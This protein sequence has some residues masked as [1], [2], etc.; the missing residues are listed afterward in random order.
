MKKI[1]KIFQK[2]SNEA[3]S[4]FPIGADAINIDMSN[5]NN[6]EEEI[7]NLWSS[8]ETKTGNSPIYTGRELSEYTWAQLEA[9]CTNNDFKDLRI[10][11][12]KTILLTDGEKV[13]MQIAGIDTYYKATDV[14]IPHHI[15]WI[16]ANCL[17]G[18]VVWN[19]T[20]NNNGDSTNN[21]PYMV[22]NVRKYLIETIYPKLPVDVKA[23]IKNK[24]N[25][26]ESRYSNYD[27]AKDSIGWTWEDMGP[28][29]LPSECEVFGTVIWGTK[30]Y[31]QC[32]AVQYPLFANSCML[33]VKNQREMDEN[34]IIRGNWWLSTVESGNSTHC[35]CVASNG[36]PISQAADQPAIG[37]P[38]CFRISA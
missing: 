1:K 13:R 8:Y 38:L 26:L 33:R 5:G 25:L 16:S 6:L 28:I 36:I 19:T 2:L 32:Q 29:W 12:Y 20:R 21:S 30:G 31:S 10:G 24:R 9:K 15:D 37:I 23:V 3:F 27:L 18:Y 11:D 4:S 7:E 22:S 17:N 14:I 35:C 34:Q